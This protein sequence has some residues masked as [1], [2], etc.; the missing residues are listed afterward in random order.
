LEVARPR[1]FLAQVDVHVAE[2]ALNSRVRLLRGH[3][4][5]EPLFDALAV[6]EVLTSGYSNDLSAVLKLLHAD[7]TLVHFKLILLQELVTVD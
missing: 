7:D 2:R 1:L 4:D 5:G 3:F 6:E